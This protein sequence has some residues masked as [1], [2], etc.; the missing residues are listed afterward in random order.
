METDNIIGWF[1]LAGASKDRLAE[2]IHVAM[3][4][5]WLGRNLRQ[6][7]HLH[8]FPLSSKHRLADSPF[9]PSEL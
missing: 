2:M 9:L 4:M 5:K 8:Q 7:D 3:L 6:S 1:G